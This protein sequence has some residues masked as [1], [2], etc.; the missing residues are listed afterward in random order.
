LNQQEFQGARSEC[1][2]EGYLPRGW[3]VP[4]AYGRVSRTLEQV[5][6]CERQLWWNV[7]APDGSSCTLN[8]AIHTITEHEDGT[9]TVMP[10][11]VTTTWH[12][13]LNR[14]IWRSV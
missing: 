12:G 6:N 9:I 2:P 3:C 13:W 14:G 10:S 5:F 4:G 8:P 7:C 1:T 11:I